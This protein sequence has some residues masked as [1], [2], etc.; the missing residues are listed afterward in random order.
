MKIRPMTKTEIKKLE[1]W[2]EECT[3]T[4][5][6][7]ETIVTAQ[8]VESLTVAESLMTMEPPQ[9]PNAKLRLRVLRDEVLRR[10]LKS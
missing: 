7:N 9:M 5:L 8:Y 2:A 4:D 10:L 1:K 6:L 3:D